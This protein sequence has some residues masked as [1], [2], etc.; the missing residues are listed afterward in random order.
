MSWQSIHL[1]AYREASRLQ[2]E[3][4]IDLTQ[5]VDPFAALTALGV[6][7]M[8][9]PLESA[10]GMYLPPNLTVGSP[11]GV[12]INVRHPLAKQR[13]TAAHELGHHRRDTT[14]VFDGDTE[15]LPRHDD[16]HAEIEKLA[17]AF[18]AWFLM[19][20]PLIN[21]ALT[22]LS[23]TPEL[24]TPALAYR[25][26]LAIHVSYRAAVHHLGDLGLITNHHRRMLLGATPRS[27]KEQL[28]ARSF[29]DTLRPDVWQVD[30][31]RERGRLAATAGDIIAIQVAEAPST[32][33]LWSIDAPPGVSQL[34][35]EWRGDSEGIGGEGLHRFWLR[36]DEPG[37]IVLNL[38]ERR[39]WQAEVTARRHMAVQ[40][41]ARP[42]PGIS[43]PALLLEPAT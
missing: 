19:P 10:A 38:E 17:E 14:A 1:V 24:L 25:Y 31:D 40:A 29:I 21:A 16:R 12:L 42:A 9:R 7:V 30:L 15:L 35:D 41:A 13:F 32:G 33:Y 4:E 27:V 39:P 37:E 5:V 2:H 26:A 6:V 22:A 18:A 3:L 8:R 11:P 34:G 20:K 43:N 36:I 28:G 23:V